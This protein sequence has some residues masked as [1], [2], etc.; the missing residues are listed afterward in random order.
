MNTVRPFEPRLRILVLGGCK[1][2]CDGNI[3]HLETAKTNALLAY[4]ALH[5]RP[6]S[7][8]KL[9]GLFWGDQPEENARRNLRHALWN[10]RQQLHCPDQPPILLSDSQEIAFNPTCGAWLDVR[11][12]EDC[13]Q[14]EAGITA[15]AAR[16]DDRFALLRQAV[17]LYCGD[18]LEGIFVDDA[19]EFEQWLLVERERLRAQALESL[20]RLVEYSVE[21]GEYATG[22]EYARRLLKMEPWLEGAHRQ[23][24]R[25]LAL[26]GQH[27]AALAQYETCRRVLA[28]ELNAEPSHE[29]QAL[30]A[31]IC[32]SIEKSLSERSVPRRKLP[33]QATPFVGREEELVQLAR[34][35]GDPACRLITL[36]GPGGSG[37]TRLAVRAA[38]ESEHFRDGI[39]FVPLVGV[40]ASELLVYAMA[41][42][43][44]LAL[45]GG[46]SPQAQIMDMLCDKEL[47]LLLDNFEHLLT[48]AEWVAEIL[49]TV[50]GVKILATSRERLNLQGEWLFQ[51]AG[52]RYP[53]QEDEATIS[54]LLDAYAAIQLFVQGTQR[55]RLGFVLAEADR[56]FVVRLCRLVD[57]MPLA[58]ELAANW[59][60]LLS[61]QEIVARIEK[62]LD[63]LT[64][65]LR[66]LPLRHRSMRAVFEQSWQ[67]LS[68]DEREIFKRLSVFR[69]GF[70][71]NEAE[72]VAGAT[73][74]RLASL[75][76]KSFLRRTPA[77]RYE[78]H[79]LLRQYGEQKLSEEEKAQAREAHGVYFARFLHAHESGLSG[80]GLAESL[81]EVAE[82]I[83][84]I[85]T[86]WNWAI[87]YRRV[88]EIGQA[89][90]SL[91][92]FYELRNWFQEG[93]AVFELA[94]E[95]LSPLTSE[96]KQPLVMTTLYN[97][98]GM[99]CSRLSRY[100]KAVRVFQASLSIARQIDPGRALYP[101]GNLA[102]AQVMHG[103]YSEARQL[104]EE[105][106][107]GLRQLDNQSS[108]CTLQ[109]NL[110][111][112]FCQIGDYPQAR[113]LLNQTL[114]GFQGCAEWVDIAF[115]HYFLG[116][117]AQGEK[118]AGQSTT[119][120]Q[121]GLAI[122]REWGHFWGA[123]CCLSGLASV[124]L[125]NRE[126]GQAAH[127]AE[128]SLSLAK[129]VGSAYVEALC[130]NCLGQVAGAEGND[131]K[132]IRYH[133][134]AIRIAWGTE[135]LPPVLDGVIGIAELELKQGQLQFAGE[136]LAFAMQHPSTCARERDRARQLFARV[137][138][139]L[140][141]Q[142][143]AAAQEW[144][145]AETLEAVV[146]R[147]LTNGLA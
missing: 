93:E 39:Y 10:I 77:G 112:V 143:L 31:S 115:A 79:E 102:T 103:A 48:G 142:A 81:E 110:G 60:R 95:A 125:Q 56:P 43:L 26:S 138:T 111:Y 104:L 57:G 127:L 83:E 141:P 49:R 123:A 17:D 19:S 126:Y 41:D 131:A 108:I 55:V 3:V 140:P 14:S 146:D 24:M 90:F 30:Y 20:Q 105:A 5:S 37:K 16:P 87:E 54:S 29:T 116:L 73:L 22:L 134:Q 23:R 88:L 42:A 139:Q 91:F 8:N 76:D 67:L 36:V 65:T 80:Q 7:R 109:N 59:M 99:F 98:Q 62:G 96:P 144:G 114:E 107:T 46:E 94:V 11:E 118:D 13:L 35:L 78:M 66:D 52:L 25:L 132:G 129:K 61:C 137:A 34:L 70:L 9:I 44:G 97:L 64:T 21:W 124:A 50:P 63:F 84:N 18:L 53:L 147:L 120:F 72:P 38:T 28:E 74:D 1:F 68:A 4:L 45:H 27:V 100:T 130:H 75:V 69:G 119:S 101:L 85:R 89:C 128:E 121:H 117:V 15:V 113:S 133:L 122:F 145:N 136:L 92:Y 33:P 51:V 135:Q 82:E 58:I 106:L 32:A 86:S 12:F 71:Q 6:Q 47:L 2:Q 40:A